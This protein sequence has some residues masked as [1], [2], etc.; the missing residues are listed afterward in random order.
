MEKGPLAI[1]IILG[2]A[3]AGFA[4]WTV[5]SLFFLNPE[6]ETQS[7][8]EVIT[9][10][11]S[12][13]VLP[14]AEACA[15]EYMDEHED[16]DIRVSGGGSSHGITSVGADTVDIGMASRKVAAGDYDDEWA[17]GITVS[18][19]EEHEIAI[20][21]DGIAVI[22]STSNT[23]APAD[24]SILQI[25][26]I[27]NGTYNDWS[28]VGSGSGSITVVGRASGSGTRSSF[29][30]F[31]G[32]TTTLDYDQEEAS[33]GDVRDAVAGNSLAI[34]YVGLGYVDDTNV[35][36][37]LVNG[38]EC[39]SA[40]VADESYELSRKLYF[41]CN[42]KPDGLIKDFIDFVKSSDGQKI[43]EDEGFVAIY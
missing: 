25:R 41:Y 24:L 6:L 42:E 20:A 32:L 19:L 27:F 38:V 16:A 10:A 15:E 1:I 33:N 22:I 11:G 31:V 18:D 40:T 13:T 12:T 7:D 35:E 28:E 37:V 17:E 4:G 14:I 30:D 29:H 39:S 43:V 8:T 34:G 3:I 21:G 9:I 26:G 2:V 36:S 23:E 5:Y